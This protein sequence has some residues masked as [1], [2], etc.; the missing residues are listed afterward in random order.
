VALIDH[1]QARIPSGRLVVLTKIGQKGVNALDTAV[2]SGACDDAEA[3]FPQHAHVEYDDEDTA[4][5]DLATSLVELILLERGG[6]APKEYESRATVVE[7]RFARYR[8]VY[9]RDYIE[10]RHT[11]PVDAGAMS[12]ARTSAWVPSDDEDSEEA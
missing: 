11:D 9:V 12:D 6:A 3:R 4:H 1:V 7:A 10:A 8:S 5:R 2:L